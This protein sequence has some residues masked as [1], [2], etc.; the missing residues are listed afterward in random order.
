MGWKTQLGAADGKTKNMIL[1][2]NSARLYKYKIQAEYK[3]LASDQLALMKQEYEA[4]GVERNN[5]AYGFVG[6]KTAA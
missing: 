6:T 4:E 1:G 2:E 3:D 5:V